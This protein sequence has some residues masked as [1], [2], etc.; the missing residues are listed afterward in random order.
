MQ[1]I[2]TKDEA[3][4]RKDEIKQKIKNGEVFIYP[5]DT[6]YGIGCNALDSKAVKKIRELKGR[7]TTPFS[8]IA[9]S[10]KWI[11]DNYIVHKRAGKWM[12]KLPGPLTLILKARNAGVAPEVA[13]GLDTI[14]IR[15]PD[16]WFSSFIEELG[17]P[18]VTTSANKVGKMFMTALEDLDQEIKEGVNFIIYEGEKKGKPSDIVHLD[19]EKRRFAR[20]IPLPTKVVKRK[21]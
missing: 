14:G 16:H 7:P 15:I 5:T 4:L 20:I 10:K 3:Q 18:V 21:K 9:P 2:I 13:P 12:N 6:I 17:I 1:E 8:V 19:K 11:E